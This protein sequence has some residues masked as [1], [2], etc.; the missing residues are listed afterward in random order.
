M[1]C[2]ILP[3]FL[4]LRLGFAGGMEI[5]QNAAL[6][7]FPSGLIDK[8]ARQPYEKSFIDV[9]KAPYKAV[10]DGVTDDSDAIQKAVDDAYRLNLVAFF[11]A[12]KTFLLSRQLKCVTTKQGSRKF[13]YQL[14]GSTRGPAPVL[15]LKAG[16]NVENNIF[17]LFQLVVN[18]KDMSASQRL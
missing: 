6:A 12:G 14:V 7:N 13:A 2:V 4:S 3:L 8:T 17:I 15:K 16:S 18:G 10:G 11:P 5:N 9:T 1:F